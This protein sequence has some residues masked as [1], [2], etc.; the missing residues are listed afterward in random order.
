MK[1]IIFG[2]VN[3]FN[4]FINKIE[5]K[6][7]KVKYSKSVTIRGKLLIQGKGKITIGENTRIKSGIKYNPIGGDGVSILVTKSPGRIEIG[8]N[9]GISNATLVAHE[10]IV[11]EDEVLIGGSVKI[12]DTD[13]HSLNYQ[14]RMSGYSGTKTA[15]VRIEKGAFIGAHSI[16]LKG[17][18]IGKYSIIGAGSVV[19]KSVPP[20]EVWAGNPAHYIKSVPGSDSEN[21]YD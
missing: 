5:L 18:T 4:S 6:R 7:H 15:P 12:Y 20:Y 21:K 13:F 11:I 3:S 2:L 8:N 16:I 19:T 14:E 17:V 1:K 9:V 10:Q